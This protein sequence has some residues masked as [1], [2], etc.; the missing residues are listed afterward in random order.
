VACEIGDDV[1]ASQSRHSIGAEH[2]LEAYATLRLCLALTGQF[3]G[4]KRTVL[5]LQDVENRE[6]EDPNDIDEVP[7][8]TDALQKPV[9]IRRD[10]SS[11]RPK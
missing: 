11:E 7:V 10:I 2:R 3:Q 4:L 5:S 8:Q 6:Q 9:A 1:V